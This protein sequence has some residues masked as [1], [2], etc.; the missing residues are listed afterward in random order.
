MYPEALLR[1]G[2]GSQSPASTLHPPRSDGLPRDIV[3]KP[4]YYGVKEE[5]KHTSRNASQLSIKGHP[6]Q[7]FA[8]LS[9]YTIKR[10]R[11]LKPLLEV[12]TQKSIKYRWS[13][14]FRLSLVYKGKTHGLSTLQEGER[15]LDHL[16]L[17]SRDPASSSGHKNS[18][19]AKRLAP[20][21]PIA[22][23][24]QKQLPKRSKDFHPP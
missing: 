20:Q 15:L 10:R 6:I 3:V 17:I 5:V 1:T 18:G 23:M 8:D 7:V 19:S 22:L 2:Q 4:H 9:L 21:S 16:G 11:T 13:F 12:L 24:W 14:P